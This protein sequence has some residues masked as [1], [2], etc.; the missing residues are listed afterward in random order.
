MHNEETKEVYFKYGQLLSISSSKKDYMFTFAAN[1]E[2]I[3]FI[4]EKNSQDLYKYGNILK[5]RLLDYIKHQE[6]DN[7]KLMV[8]INK[9]VTKKKLF[10]QLSIAS[11][12]AIVSQQFVFSFCTKTLGWA[13]DFSGFLS[14]TALA[15]NMGITT[16][17]ARNIK[18]KPSRYDR[19][20]M[21]YV[22]DKYRELA[23]FL[24]QL[25][26]AL[27]PN[28]NVKV[29]RKRFTLS[30]RQVLQ[31]DYDEELEKE[32]NNQPMR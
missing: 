19:F 20:R 30:D 10:L 24:N 18:P 29:E 5:G 15:L 9:K 14:F 31:Y 21:K 16:C 17:A 4:F 26:Y 2:P 3:E 6:E 12:I 8:E 22:N 1:P 28:D 13:T 27:R 32:K 7:D 11:V 25:N 23:K